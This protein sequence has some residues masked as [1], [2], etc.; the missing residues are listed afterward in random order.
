MLSEN[1]H[2]LGAEIAQR[3]E[4]ALVVLFGSVA[5]ANERSG[6]DIDIAVLKRDRA[7][8]SYAEFRDI[9]AGF[10][11][12][13]EKRFSKVDL[14]DLAKANILLRYE[15]MMG[16]SLLAGDPD[17]Y[18]RYRIFAFRDYVD[19]GSLRALEETLIRKRQDALRVEL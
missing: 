12:K 17:A 2:A 11:E 7:P 13:L 18:E 1:M 3:Y 10:S 4:L 16:G 5:R 9:I 14:V 19:A 15:I 6:S 8:L